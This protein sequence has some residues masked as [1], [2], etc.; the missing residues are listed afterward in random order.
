MSGVEAK[1]DSGSSPGGPFSSP[2]RR[3]K[4]SRPRRKPSK[5]ITPRRRSG[6]DSPSGSP[7]MARPRIFVSYR[8]TDSRAARMVATWL[9]HNGLEVWFAEGRIGLD[10][11][12]DLPAIRDMLKRAVFGCSHFLLLT[13]A[14]YFASKWCR[15]EA[16]LI[17]L[18]TRRDRTAVLEIGLPPDD[19]IHERFRFLADRGVGRLDLPPEPMPDFEAIEVAMHR[20][21]WPLPEVCRTV[22]PEGHPF[23]TTFRTPFGIDVPL[24]GW[25]Y[26]D[27]NPPVWRS[28]SD[29]WTLE[30]QDFRRSV[31]IA[32]EASVSFL[33][34]S[35]SDEKSRPSF[36]DST[37]REVRDWAMGASPGVPPNRSPGPISMGCILISC[38]D[39]RSLGSA[40]R[41]SGSTPVAA[42]WP[43][44]N[45]G[46]T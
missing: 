26:A 27:E 31:P 2:M 20:Q 29:E 40:T 21:G 16:H 10:Q 45:I 23:G 6:R 7:L 19:A 25:R 3:L 46:A 28:S 22:V 42:G 32:A 15:L 41:S 43:S 12:F 11:Q 4:L 17:R 30:I 33:T 14:A 36:G 35:R 9:A 37:N 38:G 5:R 13:N 8:T 44:G 34:Y 1:P 24:H 39:V 18:R